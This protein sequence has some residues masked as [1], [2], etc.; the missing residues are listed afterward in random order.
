MEESFINQSLYDKISRF[1]HRRSLLSLIFTILIVTILLYPTPVIAVQVSITGL[2]GQSI[3]QGQTFTFYIDLL[4]E[5]GER[6]PVDKVRIKVVG[7]TSFTYEFPASGG[8]QTYIILGAVNSTNYDYGAY[9]GY[10]YGYFPGYGYGYYSYPPGYGYGYGY[11]GP[12]TLRWQ[13]TLTNTA[14]L[15]VG[16]YNA[17]VEVQSDG[18]WWGGDSTKVTFYITAAPPPPPPPTAKPDLTAEFVNLP[19]TF[20]VNN[21]YD[22]KVR[23]KNIALGNAGQFNVTLTAN[24]TLVSKTLV[25]N[26]TT[27]SN[28]IITFKWKPLVKGNYNLKAT[29]DSDGKV[30]E[31]DETNNVVTTT[32][33]VESI[34]PPEEQYPD[35]SPILVEVTPTEPEVGDTC[36]VNVTVINIGKADVGIFSVRLEVNGVSIQT[37]TVDGLVVNQTRTVSF[38]WM[39]T[40]QGTYNLTAIVDPENSIEEL[41]EANNILS[42]SKLV[43]VPPTALPDLTA[44]F[45]NLP[46][47][48]QEG[49]AYQITV[50]VQNIGTGNAGQFSVALRANDI[51]VST[52]TVT[53]LA[54]GA[55]TTVTFTWSPVAGQYTL[56]AVADSGN[57]IVELD[58][59]NNAATTTITVTVAPLPWYIQ[60]WS[61]IIGVEI[62][63]IIVIAFILLRR[64]K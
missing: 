33:I 27:G 43:T 36:T 21:E 41:N 32:V 31:T 47:S 20:T 45:T 15:S 64:R 48:F 11:Y 46:T 30:A 26:L 62:I 49:T 2:N 7:P 13:A 3:T 57:A 9:Y 6:I 16:E 24:N 28:T 37:L 63:L 52:S 61:V 12:Q 40:A 34:T 44:A 54:A 8:T 5:S 18:I 39:P 60:W 22:I 1:S 56:R 38:S 53:S 14:S 4:L 59:T 42:I 17:T 58:E 23:V 19:Q 51:S 25:E 55:S 29:A 35:L 50:T 10:G